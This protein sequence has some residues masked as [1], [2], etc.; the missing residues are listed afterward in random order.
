MAPKA[1]C[2]LVPLSS[3]ASPPLA[4]PGPG[5]AVAS[6]L[7]QTGRASVHTI[8]TR[9]ISLPSAVSGC[10][11]PRCLFSHLQITPTQVNVLCFTRSWIYISFWWSAVVHL[12]L[13]LFCLISV[14]SNWKAHRNKDFSW[15]GSPFVSLGVGI[16]VWN[17]IGI[18]HIFVK[19]M[20]EWSEWQLV[21]KVDIYPELIFQCYIYSLKKGTVG[22]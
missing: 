15:F 12:L 6:C 17:I 16:H 20:N 2:G 10:P 8:P 1:L 11:L 21:Q 4:F 3:P 14:P 7:L 5:T 19:W 22:S 9:N 18:Q 13:W